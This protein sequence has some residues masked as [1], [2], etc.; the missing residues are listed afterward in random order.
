MRGIIGSIKRKVS[1]SSSS[2]AGNTQANSRARPTIQDAYNMPSRTNTQN[3]EQ[4]QPQAPPAYS[5]V[6]N[7]APMHV[8]SISPSSP[9]PP[10]ADDPYAF[11]STF[12][13]TFLI[14]DSGSMAGSNWR[15]TQAALEAI[16]PI[17]TA[18]D[19]DG[20]DM[21]FLNHPDNP[22]HHNITS[23]ATVREIFSSVRPRGGTPTGQRLDSLLRPYLRQC[24]TL[25]PDKV[26]PLNI[27]IITDGEPSDDVEAPLISCAKKLDK[28]DAPAWQIGIQFFQVGR[29]QGARAHLRALDDELDEI[30]GVELR[31]MID[32][33]PFL[34][35]EGAVLTADGILK[36]VL[37]AVNRRLDRKKS[38]DLHR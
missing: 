37:G 33:V 36:V 22:Y 3:S 9:Q 2:G 4:Q 7:A 19:T 6:S 14:D 38:R 27:I 13:T 32:T 29:D 15:E 10:I 24:E 17:C 35:K 1:S 16:T 8:P 18:H 5:P 20:I 21:I 30:A 26:K 34:G 11:L 23:A 12:D 25:G 31:D 28:L